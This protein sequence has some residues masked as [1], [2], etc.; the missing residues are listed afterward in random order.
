MEPTAMRAFERGAMATGIRKIFAIGISVMP[1]DWGG[2]MRGCGLLGC[3]PAVRIRGDRA[4]DTD[5]LWPVLSRERD[6]GHIV[7]VALGSGE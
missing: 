2:S 5:W 7:R 6:G 3:E 4:V 1:D